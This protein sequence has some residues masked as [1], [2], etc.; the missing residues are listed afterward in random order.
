MDRWI[1]LA[2]ALALL[3]F[4]VAAFVFV[5]HQG[6]DISGL[7]RMARNRKYTLQAAFIATAVLAV[8]MSLLHYFGSTFS[9]LGKT[10]LA[11]VGAAYSAAFVGFI[12]ALVTD[13]RWRDPQRLRRHRS[14][15]TDDSV[16]SPAD[17]DID[18]D[19]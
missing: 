17:I 6:A 18:T 19:R 15:F 16:D 4:F 3:G 13:V 1:V 9:W 7:R 5:L 8:D 2:L 11:V 10:L 14:P 12:C